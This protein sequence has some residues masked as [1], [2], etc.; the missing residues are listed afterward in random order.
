MTILSYL[1]KLFK[2]VDKLAVS[3]VPSLANNTSDIQE[4]KVQLAYIQGKVETLCYS[5]DLLLRS[6]DHGN[7]KPTQRR[8]T[9]R[10]T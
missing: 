2:I 10:N 9:R 3:L 5:I 4:I 6:S 8:T 1:L 7:G